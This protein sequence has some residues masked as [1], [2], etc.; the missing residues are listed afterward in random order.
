MSKF[1]YWQSWDR[2]YQIV[3]WPLLSV[4][5]AL[6]IAIL[7]LQLIGAESILDWHVLTHESSFAVDYSIFSKGP[8]SFSITADKKILTELFVGGD[9]PNTTFITKVL[10]VV[11]TTGVLLFLSLV[12]MFKRIW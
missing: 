7:V 5:F 3:F 4:F 11:I 6:I 1:F 10:M 9:M 2:P 8:F 12:T